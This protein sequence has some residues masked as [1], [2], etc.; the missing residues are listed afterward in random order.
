MDLVLTKA[1]YSV[2][3]ETLEKILSVLDE[4][5]FGFNSE[6]SYNNTD[7]MAADAALREELGAQGV[8]LYWP[9]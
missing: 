6:D 3:R 8:R 9:E 7:V 1:E 4:H 5:Q 2:S